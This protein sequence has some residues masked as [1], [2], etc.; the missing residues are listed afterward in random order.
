MQSPALP[1]DGLPLAA[2]AGAAAAAPSLAGA[3]DPLSPAGV[4]SAGGCEG[5]GR[6]PWMLCKASSSPESTLPLEGGP[7][8]CSRRVG[9]RVRLQATKAYQ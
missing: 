5:A 7:S 3:A 2:R 1:V 9:S 8:C 6:P 4:G